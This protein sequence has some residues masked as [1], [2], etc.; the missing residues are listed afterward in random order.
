MLAHMAAPFACDVAALR[1]T[2]A[3]LMTTTWIARHLTVGE[4]TD[5]VLIPGLCEGDPARH[6]G[7]GGR[8]GGE[9]T[10]RSAR[11][12][13]LLRALRR[14]AGLRRL[15]HRD[16]RGDQQ[17]S[18]PDAATRSVTRPSAFARLVPTSSISAVRPV[19]R[20]PELADVVR[21]LVDAGMRVSIDTFDVDE[22]RTAVRAGASV[23]LSVNQI[24]RRNRQRALVI[25]GQVG[26]CAGVGR[27][28]RHARAH[29]REARGVGCVV[30]RRSD[31][32]TNR[33]GVHGFTRALRQRPSSLA[34][35]RDA[36]GHWQPHGTDCGRLDRG[37]RAAHRDLPGAGDSRG[38]DDGSD[39]VGARRGEGDR[40]CASAHALRGHEANRPQG[41]RRS[42]GHREGPRSA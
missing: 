25:S 6:S 32:R 11:D 20:F 28:D 14:D 41:D 19:W 8:A 31:P 5:L 22:I 13:A 4:G 7:Q 3:A 9:G 18:T 23:V 36:D 1:I 39:P 35:R 42:A 34:G 29:D 16:P 12:T 37:Q 17:R 33:H 2:V 38:A 10:E 26:R 40:H 30:P 24:E 15:G 21:E 27:V